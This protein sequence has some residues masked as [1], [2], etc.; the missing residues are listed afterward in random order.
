MKGSGHSSMVENFL[1][2]VLGGRTESPNEAANRVAGC[3]R[4]E[5]LFR[6]FGTGDFVGNIEIGNVLN[7]LG[8]HNDA[9]YFFRKSLEINSRSSHA[10]FRVLETQLLA[11]NELPPDE[12]ETLH[13][14][15]KGMA[16]FFEAIQASASGKDVREVLEEFGDGFEP[17]DT[18]SEADWF[19]LRAA[20]KLVPNAP[21]PDR[22]E[23]GPINLF[24]YW[25]TP[26][27]PEEV[28]AN[29]QYHKGLG[30]FDVKVFS[31]EM[32]AEFLYRCYGKDTADLFHRLRHP[33]EESDFWRPHAVHAFGGYYLDVDEQV[34][35]TEPFQSQFGSSLADTFILSGTG[36]VENCFF[37]AKKG[38]PVIEQVLR[39][40][41]HNCYLRPDLSMW[42]KSGPGPI[43]RALSRTYYRHLSL[44]EAL[45]EF[46]LLDPVAFPN[47]FR[48]VP[49]S[50]RGDARDWRVFEAQSKK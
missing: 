25:D 47:A 38:S 6:K 11:G 5:E 26:N 4:A 40:L 15:D 39:N 43:T 49:V 34:I 44:G 18:G 32:A 22:I 13:S 23:N 14:L 12:I 7:K 41:L 1:N 17:F 9:L 28:E 2:R 8:R 30:I 24:F 50:Y 31:K 10:L 45:P 19:Y 36:P 27:A 20:K 42:L 48:A 35:S 29:F 16:R 33:A 46:S 37:G 21:L 3:D